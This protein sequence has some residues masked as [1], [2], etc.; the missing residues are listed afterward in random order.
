MFNKIIIKLFVIMFF[1]SVSVIYADILCPECGFKN[2]Y[3]DRY[4]LECATE[5]REIT[6]EEKAKLEEEDKKRSEH[7]QKIL[8]LKGN[9]DKKISIIV[10]NGET[11]DLVKYIKKG[12]VTIFDFY[13]D[14]CGPCKSLAPKLESFVRKTDDVCLM[15]INIKAWGSPVAQMYNIRSVPSIWIFDK[16]GRCAAQAIN[17]MPK[18]QYVVNSILKDN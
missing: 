12:K 7:K 18:I 4:C 10:K 5:L 6:S 17:G 16:K 14:W 1:V 13:A 9:I 8:K 11:V 2:L 15:K 3:E